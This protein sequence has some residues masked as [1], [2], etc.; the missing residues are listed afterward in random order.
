[1]LEIFVTLSLRI[2]INYVKT[3]KNL[4]FKLLPK[5]LRKNIILFKYKY[6]PLNSEQNSVF[7]YSTLLLFFEE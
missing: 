5:S 6:W 2:F 7:S 1:M 4:F 3:D